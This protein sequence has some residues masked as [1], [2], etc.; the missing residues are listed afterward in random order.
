MGS[1]VH[2]RHVGEENSQVQFS[3]QLV[4]STAAIGMQGLTSS[5]RALCAERFAVGKDEK[6]CRCHLPNAVLF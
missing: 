1:L 6:H 3:A 4:N 2:F 5:C